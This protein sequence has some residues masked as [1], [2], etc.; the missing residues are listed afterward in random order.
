MKKLLVLLAVFA[1]SCGTSKT[2]RTSK[3]VIKGSWILTDVT[4]SKQG[5][6][7]VNLLSDAGTDCFESSNWNFIP[8]NNSGTYTLMG[9]ACDGVERNFRFTIAEIDAET[10]YYD[11]LLK[12]TNAKGKS[13]TN[14]SGFRLHLDQLSET[15]MRWSQ[16]VDVVGTPLTIYMNF[17]KTNEP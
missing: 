14:N 9:T 1:V 6:F 3:K 15:N 4:Y 13:E 5:G 17:I 10:G 12:P 2:V 8:N 11:F 7:T 16:T